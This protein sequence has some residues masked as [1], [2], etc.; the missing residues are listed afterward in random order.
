MT[1][2]LKDLGL[3]NYVEE[4]NALESLRANPTLQQIRSHEKEITKGPKALSV[5]QLSQIQFLLGS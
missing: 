5:M 4:E 3:W 2:Y 1:I